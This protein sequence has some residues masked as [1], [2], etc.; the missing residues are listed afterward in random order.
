MIRT[1][2]LPA[3]VTRAIVDQVRAIDSRQPVTS[4]ETLETVLRDEA[5]ST[6]RFNL[7]LLTVFAALG[8]VLAV[9]GVYGV[10]SNAVAQQR[11]EIGVRM[12]LGADGGAIAR[13]VIAS[14]VRLLLIGMA[15]G[16]L[17]SVLSARLLARNVWNVPAF[18]PLAFAA[19][20]AIVSIAGLQACLW[21]ARRA[22]RT[23][24]IVAL[25]TD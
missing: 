3:G 18:D 16:L 5:Y 24:P 22:A 15:L 10:M 21:P 2:M 7:V 19:V 17:A 12:A 8:I 1:E 4:V 23:D 25:R 9:V 13:M 11:H 6:P 14:G 20:C